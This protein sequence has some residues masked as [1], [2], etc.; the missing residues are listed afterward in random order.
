M[1]KGGMAKED[2]VRNEN[3]LNQ[4][5]IVIFRAAKS[6]SGCM[7]YAMCQGTANRT[8]I[9]LAPDSPTRSHPQGAK[10]ATRRPLLFDD[11]CR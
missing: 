6:Q 3:K 1:S 9:E 10:A 2:K 11:R 8:P 7:V 5:Q 4:S